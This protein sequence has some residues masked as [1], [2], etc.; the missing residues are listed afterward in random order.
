MCAISDT[1][2]VKASVMFGSDRAMT[3]AV[4]STS[5]DVQKSYVF[6]KSFIYVEYES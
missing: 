1:L 6:L 3:V 2:S 4:K 5:G